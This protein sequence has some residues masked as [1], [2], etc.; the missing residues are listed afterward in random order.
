MQ[1]GPIKPL[2][3]KDKLKNHQDNYKQGFQ[4]CPP[5]V[6]QK[7]FMEGLFFTI[8]DLSILLFLPVLVMTEIKI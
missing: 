6:P 4:F 8:W 1:G 2:E 3:Q 7:S 5:P